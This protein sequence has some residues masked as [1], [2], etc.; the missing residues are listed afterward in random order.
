MKPEAQRIVIAEACG[1]NRLFVLMKR[2]LYYRPNAKGY[3][4]N[5]ADAWI[6]SEEEA[7]R[8]VYPYD[9]PVTKYTA[10]LPD[11]LND[12]NACHEMEKALGP[13][14]TKLW[15]DYTMLLGGI[16]A[17]EQVHAAAAQRCEAFLRTIGKWVES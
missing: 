12:L 13:F 8:H 5:A 2:G 15:H 1:K 4:R 16:M 3:T 9:E 6:L 7:N 11:Y 10:P 14:G 17:G